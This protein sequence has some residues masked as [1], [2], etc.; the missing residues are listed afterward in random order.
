M[1]N[2]LTGVIGNSPFANDITARILAAIGAASP[3]WRGSVLCIQAGGDTVASLSTFQRHF[4]LPPRHVIV[5]GLSPSAGPLDVAIALG[6][7]RA[8][9]PQP[10]AVGFMGEFADYAACHVASSSE[11]T[12]Y[13]IPYME[14]EEANDA[15]HDSLTALYGPVVPIFPLDTPHEHIA[16]W[17]ESMLETYGGS[18]ILIDAT[19]AATAERELNAV[20]K[21]GPAISY[22]F[23]QG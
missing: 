10:A 19:S 18:M 4:G 8:A 20:I 23:S 12:P 16:D 21:A 11:W 5:G 14:D 17:W 13:V 6:T 9:L 7:V 22:A 3:F 1:P 15:L 2:L